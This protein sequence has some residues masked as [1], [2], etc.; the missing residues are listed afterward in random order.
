MATA[1]QRPCRPLLVKLTNKKVLVSD[2]TDSHEKRKT[3]AIGRS[4][5]SIQMV[6]THTHPTAVGYLFA[7]P[8]GWNSKGKIAE[9]RTGQITQS[10]CQREPV[11]E[12][13]GHL[14]IPEEAPLHVPWDQV[15]H[16]EPVDGP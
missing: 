15:S 5:T 1:M 16:H 8:K 12:I 11:M 7:Q 13:K 3:P 14:Q 2:N 4:F 10:K 6:H 9:Q